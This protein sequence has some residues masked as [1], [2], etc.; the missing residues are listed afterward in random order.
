MTEIKLFTKN[1]CGKCEHVKDRMPKDLGI[2]IVNVDTVDGLAEG[3]FYEL[4]EKTFPVLVV[5]DEVA[6][7]GAIPILDKLKEIAAGKSR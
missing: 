1:D 7:E 4:I 5:D 2:Q 3:A 6:A